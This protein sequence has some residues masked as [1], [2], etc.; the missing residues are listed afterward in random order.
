MQ[1]CILSHFEN[2]FKQKRPTGKS[3]WNE[4]FGIIVVHKNVKTKNLKNLIP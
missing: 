2:D 1:T 4:N 3:N